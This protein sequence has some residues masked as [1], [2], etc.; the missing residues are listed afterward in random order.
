MPF[1][2]VSR[3]LLFFSRLFFIFSIMGPFV[4]GIHFW[5]GNKKRG[6]SFFSYFEGKRRKNRLWNLKKNPKRKFPAKQLPSGQTNIFFEMALSRKMLRQTNFFPAIS[7]KKT[8]L[9]LLLPH[10]NE[11]KSFFGS[12]HISIPSSRRDRTINNPPGRTSL[13][14]ST[15]KHHHFPH[16]H[17]TKK[18]LR[19]IASEASFALFPFFLHN[20]KIILSVIFHARKK[21]GKTFI[22]Q[23]AANP[24]CVLSCK[25]G[26]WMC[27]K[28]N[29]WAWRIA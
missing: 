13:C 1:C 3:F 29:T 25:E 2:H 19:Q 17:Y 6:K 12:C 10:R 9:R 21:R 7:R 8:L 16:K 24:A 23:Y 20:R 15:Q 4:P 27:V 26:K 14:F 11:L 18:D 22:V 5:S 28:R